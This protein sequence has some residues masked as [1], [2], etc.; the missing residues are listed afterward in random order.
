MSG[1]RDA[2]EQ[3]HPRFL[4][5][6]RGVAARTCRSLAWTPTHGGGTN[7]IPCDRRQFMHNIH[8]SGSNQ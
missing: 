1:A 6:N 5:F 3:G 4:A 8:L 7:P 2:A